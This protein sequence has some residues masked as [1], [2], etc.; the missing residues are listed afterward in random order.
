MGAD[1]HHFVAA[2]ERLV[3]NGEVISF[4]VRSDGES[5]VEQHEKWSES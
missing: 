5:F 3:S 2:I 1:P 4:H